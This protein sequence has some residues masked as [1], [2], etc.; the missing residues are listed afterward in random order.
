MQRSLI[1]LFAIFI[2]VG[3]AAHPRP[4]VNNH[5]NLFKSKELQAPLQKTLT[6]ET[7]EALL[8]KGS[9]IEGEYIT[10]EQ[11]INKMIPGSMMIP[12]PIRIESGKLRMEKITNEHK[13]FCAHH[14]KSAASFP[15]LGSVV[16]EGDCIG[17]RQSID[18]GELEWVVDNSNYNRSSGQTIWTRNMSGPEQA[19]YMPK[20]DPMPFN[21]RNLKRI[22]FDGYYDG[23]LHFT[24]ETISENNKKEKEFIFDY[25]SSDDLK[26]SIKGYRLSVLDVDSIQL[27]Y[28][29][30]SIP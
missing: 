13:Y 25:S 2:L 4:D 5:N 28:E 24:F 17:I 20:K 22:V 16:A 30:N 21:I 11:E 14:A 6:A 19:K 26:I 27:T 18:D 29:W 12:F 23:Q 10:V 9:Y 15:G 3:C 7:G 1:I 8:V